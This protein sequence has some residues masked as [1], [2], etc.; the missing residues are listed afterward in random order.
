[1]GKR[2]YFCIKACV[3]SKTPHGMSYNYSSYHLQMWKWY[4]YQHS[5]LFLFSKQLSPLPRAIEGFPILTKSCL[6]TGHNYLGFWNVVVA[7][8]LCTNQ[9]INSYEAKYQFTIHERLKVRRSTSQPSLQS[10]HSLMLG[11]KSRNGRLHQATGSL[12]WWARIWISLKWVMKCNWKLL[13]IEL[14]A[15]FVY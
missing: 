12:Q 9:T 13:S 14:P 15:I 8:A 1:M 7:L 11:I 4:Y 5:L 2:W 6:F 3:D 10:W